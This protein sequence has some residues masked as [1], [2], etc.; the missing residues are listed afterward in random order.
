[1]AW[2]FINC[3]LFYDQ[4][5]TEKIFPIGFQVCKYDFLESLSM[6]AC[7]YTI[8][9][10]TSDHLSLIDVESSDD[11]TSDEERKKSEKSFSEEIQRII[12][13]FFLKTQLSL[14]E[15]TNEAK[16]FRENLQASNNC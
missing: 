7:V 8:R 4:E 9:D 5:V 13:N 6:N 10:H 2:K 12:Q 1:M 15:L 3:T 14:T 16:V 11:G